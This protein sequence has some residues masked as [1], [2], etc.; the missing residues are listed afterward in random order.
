V[1]ILV[2]VIGFPHQFYENFKRKSTKGLSTPYMLLA[3]LAYVLW[4]VHGIL[5]D[6]WVLIVG[7]GIGI[8]TTGM[9]LYQI[10]VYKKK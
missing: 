7:Q 1:G 9:I 3:F 4:T 5:Q 2:K 6:D 10:A 8:I